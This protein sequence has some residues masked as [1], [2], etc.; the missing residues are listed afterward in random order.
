MDRAS[1]LVAQSND[2]ALGTAEVLL[3]HT[4][5]QRAN[6]FSCGYAAVHVLELNSAAVVAADCMA[7]HYFSLLYAGSSLL[8]K[9]LLSSAS[10]ISTAWF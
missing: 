3:A 4:D 5:P 6:P 1:W 7:L 8:G 10:M 2:G 9:E